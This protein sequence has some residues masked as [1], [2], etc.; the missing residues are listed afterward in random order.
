MDFK[1]ADI[2]STKQFNRDDILRICELAKEMEHYLEGGKKSE[3]LNGYVMSTVFFEPSTRTRFSH[4]V[5]MHNLGGS[6]ISNP[7]MM[8]TSS[9][10]KQETLYDTGKMLGTLADVVVMR[11]PQPGSVAELAKGADAPVINAG[12]GPAEHP[13]QGLLDVY[14]I[15]KEFGSLDGLTVG[16]IGDLKNSRVQHSELDL[17]KHF[18]VKFV[19]VSPDE[20]KMPADVLE[21]LKEFGCEFSEISDF[22]SVISDVDVISMSR[23]QEERFESQAEYEKFRGV[24]VLDAEM[25]KSAKEN[26]IVIQPLPR[27]DE[28]TIEV[29]EDSR[30][31][32]FEQISNG[33]AVRMALLAL[34]LGKA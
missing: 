17:L 12:D 14:T 25:M 33:V 34:I 3:L 27:V 1:G 10:K 19:L 30:A 8:N 18:D 26:A 11:H 24:Y 5:A 23:I 16:M 13:T 7:D 6:V 31:K 21:D 9:I 29:D 20:L 15:W 32:Y 2:L 28:V 4:E 22:A